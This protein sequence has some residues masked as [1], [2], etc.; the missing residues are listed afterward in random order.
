L[1]FNRQTKPLVDRV[2]ALE[3]FHMELRHNVR[4][5]ESYN[6]VTMDCFITSTHLAPT[7]IRNSMSN[8]DERLSST[9]ELNRNRGSTVESTL[10]ELKVEV[11]DLRS[12]LKRAEK[13]ANLRVGRLS[14]S[15]IHLFCVY[16]GLG[17]NS[18]IFQG[19]K[20]IGRGW[21][22]GRSKEYEASLSPLETGRALHI[23]QRC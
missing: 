19:M 4:D 14:E 13:D 18:P 15:I 8:T 17:H 5:L 1:P 10:E 9:D 12:E 6:K 7:D 3:E 2:A 23:Q 20:D 16:Q 11:K 21:D 22:E